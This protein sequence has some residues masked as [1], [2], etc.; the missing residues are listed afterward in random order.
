MFIDF[1]GR[2]EEKDRERD[3]N[4]DR[5]LPISAPTGIKPTTLGECFYWGLNCHHPHLCNILLYGMTF[6]LSHPNKATYSLLVW[7]STT[8]KSCPKVSTWCQL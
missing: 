4:I 2:E 6:Q 8:K 1:R 3:R 7:N 5:L